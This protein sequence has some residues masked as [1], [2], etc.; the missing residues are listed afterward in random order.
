MNFAHFVD[1]QSRCYEAAKAELAAGAKR[2]HWM[3]F[4]FPQLAGLGRSEMARRFGLGSIDEA[5]RYAAHPLLGPRLRECV[6]LV[7][8]V[9]G[10]TAR[11]IFGAPDDVKFRSC[12]TL[13]ARATGDARFAAALARYYE[14]REDPLTVALLAD[15]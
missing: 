15:G 13:F 5:R 1:A 7:L 4:V 3:W 12:L 11:E 2:A 9:E 10:K 8:A 6:D 14:G